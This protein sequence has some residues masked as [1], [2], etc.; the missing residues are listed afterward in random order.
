MMIRLLK[1]IW[2]KIR[3]TGFEW[4]MEQFKKNCTTIDLEGKSMAEW[5]EG[6]EDLLRME[7]ELHEPPQLENL[8]F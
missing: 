2:R 6:Q 5:V 4:E 1:A 3:G 7:Y 8:R